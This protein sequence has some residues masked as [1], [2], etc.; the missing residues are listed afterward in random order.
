V[1]DL[2]DQSSAWLEDQREK[3]MSRSVIYQRGAYTVDVPA[4][5]G[6]T[7]FT[8]D[9]GAGA[10]LRVES[11]DYLIRAAH[12]VLNGVTELP[13]RGDQIHEMVDGVIFVYEVLGPGDEPHFRYSDPYRRTLRIHTKQVDTEVSP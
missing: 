12:L 8:L 6:S 13:K 5:I 1:A 2:L 11:R 9:D 7:A 10:I 3:H 4:T